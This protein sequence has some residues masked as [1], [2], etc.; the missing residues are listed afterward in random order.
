MHLVWDWNGTLFDDADAVYRASAE[1]FAARGLPEITPRQYRAA[2][3]RPISGFY[4]RLFG[5]AL[6]PAELAALDEQFH[7]AYQ[8]IVGQL[9][10]AAGA[11][12]ALAGW[13]ARGGD[14][15]LL[16]M[17]RHERLLALV[18]RFA[19]EGEFTRVAGLLGAADGR[20]A[21]HLARHM[22]ALRLDPVDV[23]LIGDGLDDAAAAAHV[24]ARC[25]LYNG[26]AHEHDA[27]VATGLPVADDLAEAVEL[28]ASR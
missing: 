5:R 15:S 1:L 20:K 11:R 18:R 24:G 8:R 6:A 28:A 25:V 13:R 9:G 3:C 12:S 17:Y 22:A 2:Y 23:A 14:Q 26:G 7:A 21:E 4:A 27:L 16:S 10:L 19:L